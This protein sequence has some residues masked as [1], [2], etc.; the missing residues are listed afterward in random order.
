MVQGDPIQHL[1]CV[2]PAFLPRN[3]TGMHRRPSC[4]CGL[5]CSRSIS[6]AGSQ[7]STKGS[8]PLCP[9]TGGRGLQPLGS[10]GHGVRAGQ[11]SGGCPRAQDSGP[12]P[13]VDAQR[14][15]GLL[16]VP[17]LPCHCL[18]LPSAE[19]L[20]HIQ[21]CKNFIFLYILL[22]YLQASTFSK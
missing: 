1:Q 11:G 9:L 20:G 14:E 19:P 7:G 3:D 22:L 10:T 4:T 17:V 21:Y 18:Q 2:A 8:I 16:L 13:S 6:C 12:L 15:Q 5:H